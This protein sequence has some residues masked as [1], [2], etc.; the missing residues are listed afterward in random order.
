MQPIHD[1]E[2]HF[3]SSSSFRRHSS[4]S[5]PIADLESIRS[6]VT[7]QGPSGIWDRLV[8]LVK[9]IKQ[10]SSPE[11]N[12]YELAPKAAEQTPSAKYAS[13]TA[14]D[15]VS[16]L[17][18]SATHGLTASII[19]SLREDY[20]YN[21][22]SVSAPEPPL[23]KFA[24]SF[25]ESPLILLLCGS[26]LVSAIM[27]NVDDAVSIS[28]AVVI[29]LTVGFVQERRSEQS[30]E[31][32]NKLVPHHCHI[33]RDGKQLHLLANEAVPGDL[34]TFSTGD[35]IPADLRIL[36][37][38]DLEVDESSL[39]GETTTRTK[40]PA[41]CA[42]GT[43][44]AERASIAYMGTLVRNGR[45]TGIVIATGTQT[46]FGIIF[47][48]MQDVEERRTPLQHSMDE[49]AKKLSIIS[50]G[51]IGVI[52]LVGVFQHRPWLDMFTIGVSLAVAAIP[53]GLPIVTTV[54]LALGVL[55]MAKRKAIVKKLHS[56]E[57][58]GSVSVI[59]SDKTGTLTRNEQTVTEL[60]TVDE[61]VFVDPAA[62]APPAHV[63]P[64]LRKTLEVGALCNDASIARDEDGN[65]VGQATD[66]ALLNVLSVFG[67]PD[68]RQTFKRVFERPFS[69]ETKSMA[70][71]GTH[72]TSNANVSHLNGPGRELYHIKGSMDVLLPRCK[73][74]HVADGST[75]LLDQNMR[76]GI[77]SKAQAA[78]TRGLR[79]LAMAYG[80]AD[81]IVPSRPSSPMPNNTTD[82]VDKDKSAHLVFAG[83]VAMYDPPR[84]GVADAVAHLQ[85][86]GVQVIMITGDGEE[87]ALSIAKSL[88]LRGA[89]NPNGCLTG[90]ALDRMTTVQ[91]SERLGNVSVFARVSPKHKMSIVEA[92]QA[93]GAVVAMTGD[94][95]N[96]APALKMADIGISM[97]KSGTDVAKEAADVILVDDNF[98]TILPAVEEGKSIFHNIQNF[99]SFQLSTAAA[100]LTLITL[101]TM[102]GLSNPLNAMQILFINILM[103]G[104]PSQS[105]GV[106]PVDHAVMRKPPRKKDEPIIDRRIR[107]RVLFSA[108]IIVVGTLFIYYFAL[109]DD[110]MSRRDQ[111]MTFTCFVFLDLVSAIQNRGLGCGL[112][113][114]RMLMVTVAISF[115]S[116]LALVYVPFMQAIFQ[117]EA[118][119]MDDLLLLLALAASSFILHESRRRYER[120]LNQHETYASAVEELA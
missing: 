26:A 97:G 20:G 52:C 11:Q 83:F 79:V 53:E 66:V 103:D 62:P 28:I 114:N 10:G 68:P 85:R 48:M 105:L 70:I 99:L 58:L 25:Y 40:D 29:V 106:D 56:V 19:S 5:G 84:K 81:A 59:C 33:I 63:S 41:P 90:S 54:T 64:A 47:S 87:T 50:F 82:Y 8:G 16:K 95:V 22:F 92:F 51:I 27:G 73:F 94:G 76:S 34:V 91:L 2:R 31:S 111:T 77:A 71:S 3:G 13:Y 42:E 109:S 78:S 107:F 57:A 32:L 101:S 65:Y 36:S 38:A 12:G 15:V 89:S 80:N 30:L 104:P 108:T 24:K 117:T 60:Y 4:I 116:Q 43:E 67:L 69:S 102:F 86:G 93:R 115:L 96:D 17:G 14:E 113:Q 55:R 61:L 23:L 46:E 119:P 39:T 98:S 35:R 21:E 100:A 44:M 75:P 88:G 7:E 118:L 37:A 110:Q 18:S 9:G 1:A 120:T 72:T 6:A 74:Y 112:T 49:L 45:G